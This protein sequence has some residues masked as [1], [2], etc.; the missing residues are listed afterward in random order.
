MQQQ[1][2]RDRRFKEYEDKDH[3]WMNTRGFTLPVI[4]ET[5]EDPFLWRY[6]GVGPWLLT[7]VMEKNVDAKWPKPASLDEGAMRANI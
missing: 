1:D 5:G 3:K 6:H 4:D 2:E 7:F